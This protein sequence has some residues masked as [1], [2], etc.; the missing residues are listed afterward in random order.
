MHQATGQVKRAQEP[1]NRHVY[2]LNSIRA[3]AKRAIMRSRHKW[4]HMETYIC[5][6]THT[7][8]YNIYICKYI[9]ISQ[10]KNRFFGD[11]CM[12][13]CALICVTYEYICMYIFTY[14]SMKYIHLHIYTNI[15]AYIYIY[16]YVCVWP[17]STCCDFSCCCCCYCS[18]A[19]FVNGPKRS[20][21]NVSPSTSASAH[22]HLSHLEASVR[23][24]VH[25]YIHI[26]GSI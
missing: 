22:Q 10:W 14:I 2:Q 6:Y 24:C 23:A 12:Q 21:V 5:T 7:F 16:A 19:A 8:T 18:I 25:N 15:L 4:A 1:I 13:R 26:S 9:K 17:T 3:A 11:K 20:N